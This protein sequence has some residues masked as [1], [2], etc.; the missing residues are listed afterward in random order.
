M[1]DSNFSI[2]ALVGAQTGRTASSTGA[3]LT[4]TDGAN[5]PPGA[6]PRRPASSSAGTVVLERRGLALRPLVK[7][8]NSHPT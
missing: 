8:T 2:S 6:P 4:G 5:D 7:C 1:Q 3:V